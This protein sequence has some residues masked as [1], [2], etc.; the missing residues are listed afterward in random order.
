MNGPNL[1]SNSNINR[2]N[3]IPAPNSVLFDEKNKRFV[4]MNHCDS[5]SFLNYVRV[6]KTVRLSISLS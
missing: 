1:S 4:D 6:F 3:F 2:H 5:V